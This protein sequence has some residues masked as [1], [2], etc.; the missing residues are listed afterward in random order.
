[1]RF[2]KLFDFLWMKALRPAHGFWEDCET[3]PLPVNTS[4]SFPCLLAEETC[5]PRN[6]TLQKSSRLPMLAKPLVPSSGST[7]SR[8]MALFR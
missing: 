2:K 6:L 5:L 4:S 3:V 1:M 7:K 8:D